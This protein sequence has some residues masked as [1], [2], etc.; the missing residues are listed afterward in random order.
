[1]GVLREVSLGEGF[2]P[3]VAFRESLGFIPNLFRAQTLLP[4]VIE[5]EAGIAAAVLL[6]PSALTR[7]QKESILL[8]VAAANE[9]AYC[10][11][12]HT[13]LLRT[14]GVSER[15]IERM[16]VD[17]RD[18]GLS[19]ADTALLDFALIL[20]QEPTLVAHDDVET[21][22]RHGFT[23]EQILEAVLMAALTNFLCTLAVGLDVAPDFAPRTAPPR[24]TTAWSSVRKDAPARGASTEGARA[25]YLRAV[26]VTAESFVP[27][28]FFR[29]RFGFIPNIF[30]AQTLRPD[31]LEAEAEVVR[32]ILLSDDVLSR[33]RKEYI[34][35]VVSAANF[36]TYCVAV[37]CEMLRALGVPADTSDRVALDHRQAGLPAA[38]VALL[39]FAL[40]LS[41]R[42]RDFSRADVESLRGL[43]FTEEQILEAVV[44][45]SLTEF[46]NTLQMGLGTV[47][48]FPPMRV[49][50]TRPA[51]RAAAAP[52]A[53][54]VE[55]DPDAAV[56]ARVR[57]GDVDAFEELVRR[58]GA[59]TYRSL[60]YITGTREDAEDCL[61]ST[62]LKVFQN[63]GGFQGAARFSTWLTRIAV[64]EGLQRVRGDRE[65]ESL[66][67]GIADGDEAF[68]P[69]RVQAWVDDPEKACS[70]GEMRELVEK[71]LL[72]LP[73]KY[74][75]AVMLRDVD[76]LSTEEAA[77]ALGLNVA[78]L[79]TRLSRGRLMLREAL[80]PHFVARD[81]GKRS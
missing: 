1:V 56:V 23:D 6:K 46:L 53:A 4:R 43:G 19:E 50:T 27:F 72:E 58:H 62:F 13:Q 79:K 76:E 37:H 45:T 73:L 29:E 75:M 3:F 10:V 66:D 40:K 35:L 22:R 24:G 14:L 78:T 69:Q 21:L 44:M 15:R 52:A 63:I 65:M 47:P 64:N 39:D 42:P 17:H 77:A 51:P 8:T 20:S 18:A 32:A 48:D 74:R 81:Q 26:D 2:A 61:Q 7:A 49:F 70:R 25:P 16:T 31:V 57:A 36:N 71:E 68:Q 80:A 12:A 30:R 60:R 9:N 55:P 33:V 34:L 67:E 28:V 5:A 11:T 41:Q 59:R 54:P 38:D